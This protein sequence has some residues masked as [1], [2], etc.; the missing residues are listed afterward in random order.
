MSQILPYETRSTVPF[1]LMTDS[2]PPQPDKPAASL[3]D[4]CSA[5]LSSGCTL[6]CSATIRLPAVGGTVSRQGTGV[7]RIARISHGRTSSEAAGSDTSC[8]Q[9]SCLAVRRRTG[10]WAFRLR[11]VL[12]ANARTRSWPRSGLGARTARSRP[13][14]SGVRRTTGRRWRFRRA[15]SPRQSRSARA[16]ASAQPPPGCRTRWCSG[17]VRGRRGR[18]R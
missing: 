7:R 10:I 6:A 11:R 2:P 9:P 1:V 15:T 8:E 18:R 4:Y 13:R 14:R 3:G 12:V 16:C 5:V 17:P